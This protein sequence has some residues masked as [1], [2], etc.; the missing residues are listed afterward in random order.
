MSCSA[1]ENC[2][3]FWHLFHFYKCTINIEGDK[4][5]RWGGKHIFSFNYWRW[6]YKYIWHDSIGKFWNKA[7]KCN[8]T[9]HSNTQDI[10]C[11]GELPRTYCFDCEQYLDD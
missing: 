11:D 6:N 1:R 3:I 10:A 5:W 4:S 2:N 9:K 7:I 8:I